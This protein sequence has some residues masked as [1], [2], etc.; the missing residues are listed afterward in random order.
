M[1]LD[2]RHIWQCWFQGINHKSIPNLNKRCINE[3]SRLNPD[4]PI[5][6]LDNSN[7]DQ[8]CPEFSDAGKGLK[9][10]L[11]LKSD[12]L[13]ICLLKKYG[14]VWVDASVWP[15]E[16]L[17]NFIGSILNETGFFAYR[18]I[19]RNIGPKGHRELSSWFMVAAKPEHPVIVKI[20]DNFIKTL[21]EKKNYRYFEF[22][23]S[24]CKLYDADEEVRSCINNMVQIS[25]SFPH[26]AC[27]GWKNRKPSFLY[28]RPKI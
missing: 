21:R 28:K 25:E 1:N 27:N 3:W 11:A 22:H 19:P 6:L 26:S 20:H 23:D 5:T 14:G 16:P 24:I 12:L 18:F 13:R 7:I 8:F 10:S 2:A 17:S 9:M 15:V 4:W